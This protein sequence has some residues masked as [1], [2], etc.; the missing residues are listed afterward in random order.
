MPLVQP[1]GMYTSNSCL[2][3]PSSHTWKP[4]DVLDG[5]ISLLCHLPN[6]QLPWGGRAVKTPSGGTTP[7]P[8]A[9]IIFF[10]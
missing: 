8:P 1:R 4:L 5:H 2:E 3:T 7:P 6:P 9:S 10:F